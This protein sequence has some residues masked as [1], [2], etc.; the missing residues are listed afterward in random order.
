[1]EM[2]D[3]AV[4]ID[5]GLVQQ[6]ASPLELYDRP[7][8]AFVMSFV[9]PV[10]RFDGALRRPHDVEIQSVRPDP[11]WRPAVVERVARLGFEVRVHIRLFDGERIWSQISYA[12]QKGKNLGPGAPVFV[13]A[14]QAGTWLE[15]VVA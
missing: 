13:K 2:A 14:T 12:D 10:T 8:N 6:I 11:S 3:Q 9:G 4:V 15:T 1:M 7:A 5:R